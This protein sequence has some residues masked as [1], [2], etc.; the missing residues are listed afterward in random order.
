MNLTAIERKLL[1][2]PRPTLEE[3]RASWR[4]RNGGR[5]RP[6]MSAPSAN[7]KIARNAIRTWSLALSP[8]RHGVCPRSTPGCRAICLAFA[9]RNE[10]PIAE[11]ARERRSDFLAEEP[12]AFLV[13]W[14]WE[15][16]RIPAGCGV[17]ANALSDIRWEL[18][19]PDIIRDHARRGVVFY[20]YTKF[21]PSDRFLAD[22]LIDLTFS[23]SER[24]S[25]SAIDA[26]LEAGHRVAVVADENSRWWSH[27][28]AID[29]DVTDARFADERGA[30]VMLRPKGRRA[31][32]DQTGFVRR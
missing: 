4:E 21:S 26:A 16:S 12:G 5:D 6:L 20:D 1:I 9:G 27:P 2:A 11:S 29:G 13:L 7:T 10:M 15:L 32:A 28:L 24:W 23:A 14:D 8:V 18:C 19:A 22:G 25:D 3:A 17:R 30:L 31:A